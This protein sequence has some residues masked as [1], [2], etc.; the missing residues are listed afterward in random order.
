ML[1]LKKDLKKSPHSEILDN[2]ARAVESDGNLGD[3]HQLVVRL[4][5]EDAG[6]L[7]RPSAI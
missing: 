1:D 5:E 6:K 7:V 3:L 4:V 2:G